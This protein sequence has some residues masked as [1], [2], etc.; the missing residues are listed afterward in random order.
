MIPRNR[1]RP[2]AATS[3]PTSRSSWVSSTCL[4]SPGAQA[5]PGAD[6]AANARE[7]PHGANLLLDMVH[8]RLRQWSSAAVGP[9]DWPGVFTSSRSNPSGYFPRPSRAAKWA[10]SR[11]PH[12]R[13]LSI[14]RDLA[15]AVTRF[16][17]RSAENSRPPEART[18]EPRDR[19]IQSLLR[20]RERMR[21]GLA[22]TR[23]PA[24]FS[25]SSVHPGNAAGTPSHP[26][27]SRTV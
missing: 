16:N 23:R 20:P 17:R 15:A 27:R 25:R 1:R 12:R 24:L 19:T 7:V 14:G 3:R 5:D 6:R 26:A 21:H 18:G 8:M 11:A 4:P 10:S 9:D 22:S 13:R 2:I